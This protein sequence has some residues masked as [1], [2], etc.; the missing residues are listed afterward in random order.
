MNSWYTKIMKDTLVIQGGKRLSGTVVPQGAKNEAFQVL[1]AIL[2]TEEDVLMKNVPDILDIHNLFALFELLGVT[3]VKK[4]THTFVCNAKH[5]EPTKMETE[6]FQKL[7]SKLRGSLMIAGAMLAR[8]GVGYVP[9]PGGDKIGVRPVTVHTRGFLD[10]GGSV[11]VE[12]GMLS[13]S[14]IES[15]R[16]T[17]REASVTGTANIILA[18]V[19]KKSGQD[20]TVEIYNAACEPYIQQ[21]I[22]MLNSMGAK[23]TGSGTNLL[24]IEG[25]DSLNG[26]EHI[27][28]PDMIEIGSWVCLAAAVGDGIVIQGAK[29]E[30]LGDIACYIFGKLGV[31]IEQTNEGLFIPSHESIDILRPSTAGKRIRTIYDDRWPGLSPDHLSSMIAMCT[32]ANGMVTF[33]QRMFDRRLLFCDKLNDMGADII[34][35]HHQEITVVGNKRRGLYG[36]EMS[37]PDI[38]AGMALVIAALIANGKSII[39]NAGQIHRGYENIVERLRLLGADIEEID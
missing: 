20:H 26:T 14:R 32:Q 17:L 29:R 3:I 6:E 30:D 31:S 16:I 2:L 38:R 37:S 13:L 28:A 21:L 24:I 36:M 1:A 5:I 7:F 4:D 12:T 34:M 35:S 25:V 8:F 15:K 18:S 9:A 10:L 19:L 27:I 39:K 23:I 11:D 33:R 22:A